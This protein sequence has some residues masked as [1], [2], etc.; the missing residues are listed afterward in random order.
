MTGLKNTLY[1]CALKMHYFFCRSKYDARQ[2]DICSRGNVYRECLLLPFKCVTFSREEL[3]FYHWHS[4]SSR[5]EG[6]TL[7]ITLRCGG[8][9]IDIITMIVAQTSDRWRVA[10]VRFEL[11]DLPRQP[12]LSRGVTSEGK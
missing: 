1:Q 8:H 6:N 7:N 11:L 3:A 5:G 2:K 12:D 9:P 4:N 10:S